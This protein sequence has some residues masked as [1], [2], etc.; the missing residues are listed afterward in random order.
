MAEKKICGKKFGTKWLWFQLIKKF[1]QKFGIR[2][3]VYIKYFTIV[4][5]MRDYYPIYEI[6]PT[7][8]STPYGVK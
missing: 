8:L 6:G 3:I 4:F 7:A 1:R 2:I 5:G